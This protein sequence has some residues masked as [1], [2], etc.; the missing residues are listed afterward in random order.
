MYRMRLYQCFIFWKAQSNGIALGM[1]RMVTV[2]WSEMPNK[3][4]EPNTSYLLRIRCFSYSFS[5]YFFFYCHMHILQ[6]ILNDSKPLPTLHWKSL[7]LQSHTQAHAI[8]FEPN[9][10]VTEMDWMN[11]IL[12]ILHFANTI[13]RDK[14]KQRERMNG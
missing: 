13:E 6:T 9:K 4:T 7:S 14:T 8:D 3:K 10:C 2:H 12:D 1:E 5:F 11:L